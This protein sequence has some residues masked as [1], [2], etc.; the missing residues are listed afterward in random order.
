MIGRL[1][2]DYPD[3]F[4]WLALTCAALIAVLLSSGTTYHRLAIAALASAIAWLLLIGLFEGLWRLVTAALRAA[5]IDETT[6]AEPKGPRS[7]L[8]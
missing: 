3:F 6:P 2:R 8:R 7:S 5:G 4:A 1:K